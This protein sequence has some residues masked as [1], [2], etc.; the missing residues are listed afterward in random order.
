MCI[1]PL[2]IVSFIRPRLNA[3]RYTRLRH[4]SDIFAAMRQLF[5]AERARPELWFYHLCRER[6]ILT[7]TLTAHSA[8]KI[9][10]PVLIRK[11]E[12]SAGT[13]WFGL[14]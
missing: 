13:L 14:R 5:S 6:T 8:C 9:C 7:T 1:L 4:D 2:T 12:L 11:G 10:H 3:D